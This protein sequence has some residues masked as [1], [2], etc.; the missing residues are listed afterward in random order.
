MASWWDRILGRISAEA[1]EPLFGPDFLERLETLRILFARA[2]GLRE[3]GHIGA[4][5]GGQLLFRDY[6]A[7]APGDDFRRVDWNAFLRLDRLFVKEYE[8]EDAAGI[9]I[10]VDCSASMAFGEPSKWRMAR[11]V[12]AMLAY[13]ALCS[14]DTVDIRIF[15]GSAAEGIGPLG[16]PRDIHDVLAFL[17]GAKTG[18]ATDMRAACIRLMSGRTGGGRI[19]AF[20]IS[21]FWC[22]EQDIAAFASMVRGRGHRLM[23]IHV[24]SP[25]EL[26]LSHTGDLQIVDSETGESVL[27]SATRS[28]AQTYGRYVEEHIT[29][30]ERAFV[31][32]GARHA[33]I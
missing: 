22:G 33:L 10:W 1:E 27:V 30:V 5:S 16:V 32:R 31:S 13:I 28:S 15:A 25:E 17:R 29:G 26:A 18:G 6:R 9:A 3:G 11:Q 21:D 7:Y 12:A 8:R 19:S 14:H 4:F 24:L 23:A 2:S 20:L